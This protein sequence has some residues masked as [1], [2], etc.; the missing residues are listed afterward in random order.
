MLRRLMSD[1]PSKPPSRGFAAAIS[2]V[3]VATA[4]SLFYGGVSHAPQFNDPPWVDYV[5]GVVFLAAGIQALATAFGRA[6]RGQWVALIFFAGI[7][8]VF[9]WIA[10][11]SDPRQCFAMIGP[12]I[13]PGRACKIGFGFFAAF[14]TAL[15]VYLARR[16]FLPRGRPR[17][18]Y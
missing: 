12:F 16:L 2:A 11:A 6:G 3:M 17:S 18:Y 13:L 4:I 9:W 14:S 1:E 7:A 8:S 10:V 5:L 15:A